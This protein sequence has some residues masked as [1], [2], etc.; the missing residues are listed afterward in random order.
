[1]SQGTPIKSVGASAASVQ[2][3]AQ[4][5]LKENEDNQ[6]MLVKLL[7]LALIYLLGNIN[8]YDYTYFLHCQAFI[9]RLFSVLR[10]ESVI[11]EV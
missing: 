2:V 1:M 7:A 9:T 6:A 4:K 3:G 10:F 11:H 5:T 8:N